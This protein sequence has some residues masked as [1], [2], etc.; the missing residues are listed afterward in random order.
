MKKLVLTLLLGISMA[1][2][3]AT[4]AEPPPRVSVA[5]GNDL[6]AIV[7]SPP[8]GS[9]FSSFVCGAD[10]SKEYEEGHRI[11][12]KN[13]RYGMRNILVIDDGRTDFPA[14]DKATGLPIIV[15]TRAKPTPEFLDL[16]KGYN[17]AMRYAFETRKKESAPA[18]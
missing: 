3:I 5:P 1:A 18:H 7:Y 6:S 10:L 4:A 11:G 9:G 15:L 8:P 16:V 13:D 12:S 17:S 14:T 2:T